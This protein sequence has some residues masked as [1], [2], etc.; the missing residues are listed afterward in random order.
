MENTLF[1][2]VIYDMEID[3]KN[4]S[5]KQSLDICCDLQNHSGEGQLIGERQFFNGLV[6]VVLT[7]ACLYVVGY[8]LKYVPNDIDMGKI[9]AT[10]YLYFDSFKPEAPERARY[11][12]TML[13]FPVL[14]VLFYWRIA[15]MNISRSVILFTRYFPPV[16]LI[17]EIIAFFV[18]NSAQ[19]YIIQKSIFYKYPLPTMLCFFA[20]FALL[21]IPQQ[22]Y[23]R[24]R[25]IIEFVFL[26]ACVLFGV[27]ISLL[28]ITGTP[29]L[30][31]QT[32]ADF[33]VYYY[34]VFEVFNGKTLM[35]DFNNIYGFYPYLIVPILKL[36]GSISIQK[37]NFIVAILILISLLSL[38]LVVWI[39]IKNKIIAVIGYFSVVFFIVVFPLSIG[40]IYYA[41]QPHRIIFPSLILLAG[42]LYVHARNKT[43]K[44]IVM[45]FGF[46]TTCLSL[47][48]NIDTGVVVTFAWYL[49]LLYTVA[50]N[51]SLK[52]WKLYKNA[53]VVSACTFLSI[54]AS[55]GIITLIT[56]VKSGIWIS[57]RQCIYAQGI[58]Y[59]L[60][61]NM[62]P[63][64]EAHPWVI[65]VIL[66]AIG[67]IISLRNL[68]FIANDKT[69]IIGSRSSMYF[70]VSII[71]VGVFSYYQGRS[72]DNVFLAVV[73]PG[74]I[75][76]V[77]LLE[78]YHTTIMKSRSPYRRKDE[79]NV[80]K[81][82]KQCENTMERVFYWTNFAKYTFLL[83]ILISFMLAAPYTILRDPI[84][85]D[86]QH[87]S[88]SD[89]S[90]NVDYKANLL[91]KAIGNDSDVNLLVREQDY[92][93][94]LLGMKNRTG[95]PSR[96]DWI[97]RGDYDKV[98]FWLNTTKEKVIIDQ[99]IFELLSYY[100]NHAV[101]QIIESRYNVEVL[102]EEYYLLTLKGE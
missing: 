29:T 20:F 91:K 6:S 4:K 41:Y 46:L 17:F 87:G 61:F 98:M 10:Y 75:I 56:F 77:M 59:N 60:G 70:F 85:S 66:F 65:L 96:V 52:D 80:E 30:N 50:L 1:S 22:K 39:N 54:T 23:H 100:S 89:F 84:F 90:K 71:G 69:N 25:K 8:F 2:N 9:K 99:H 86:M 34:P 44:I 28:Y 15:R 53:L 7:L 11:I 12:M 64:P 48:W 24:T 95:L 79:I 78:D 97:T 81:S 27:Y 47:I 38:L 18:E 40:E 3:L 94:T 57:V 88:T 49:L 76:A 67:L 51:Y 35:V 62:L 101:R 63:M 43:R 82:D 58:F 74:A 68:K 32:F 73:W 92:Y 102:G 42:T 36:T 55:F 93:N 33:D 16:I 5:E 83:L 26:S 14:F 13:L 21:W 31:S 37:F 72:H 19:S 45:V